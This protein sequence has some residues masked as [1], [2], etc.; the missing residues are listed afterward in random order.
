M[1]SIVQILAALVVV[2]I[3]D[4]QPSSTIGHQIWLDLSAEMKD[5]TP[6]ADVNLF[7]VERE[8]PKS[9]EAVK[10]S[11]NNGTI[12][13][14]IFGTVWSMPRSIKEVKTDA[15]SQ[16]DGSV[17]S[18]TAISAEAF[19]VIVFADSTREP[20]ARTFVPQEGLNIAS[21]RA[22]LYQ[23]KNSREIVEGIFHTVWE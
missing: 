14:T 6:E 4:T 12:S 16:D 18:A 1:I 23:T 8:S 5:L 19:S 2:Y 9:H 22:K 3:Q 10:P 15:T 13:L 20:L 17:L 7:T 21:I 11:E